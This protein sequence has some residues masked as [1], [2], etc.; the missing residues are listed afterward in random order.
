MTETN[1]NIYC[2][3]AGSMSLIHALRSPRHLITIYAS[4]ALTS[5]WKT[6]INAT[7]FPSSK[8]SSSSWACRIDLVLQ[9]GKGTSINVKGTAIAIPS[10]KVSPNALSLAVSPWT[11]LILLIAYFFNTVLVTDVTPN[12]MAECQHLWFTMNGWREQL[13]GEGVGNHAMCFFP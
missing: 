10:K 13:R 6:C 12:K 1:K 8:S 11:A 4:A 3:M 2:Y 5:N 9:K 7:S